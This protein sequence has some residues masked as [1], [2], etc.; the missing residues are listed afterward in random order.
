MLFSEIKFQLTFKYD[1]IVPCF[2]NKKQNHTV[3]RR[4]WVYMGAKSEDFAKEQ[5]VMS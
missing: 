5:M 1:P 3:P 4:Q 2:N